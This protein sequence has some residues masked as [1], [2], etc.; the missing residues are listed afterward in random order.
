MDSAAL[1]HLTVKALQAKRMLE[2]AEEEKRSL[3]LESA[4]PGCWLRKIV[5]DGGGCFWRMRSLLDA[6]GRRCRSEDAGE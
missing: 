2:E 4:E 1:R 5:G 3:Q 6:A